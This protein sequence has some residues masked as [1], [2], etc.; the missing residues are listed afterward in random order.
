[1]V[2]RSHYVIVGGSI[3]GVS[4]A[5]AMRTAGFDGRISI[6]EASAYLP[7]ERPPLSKSLAHLRDP[8]PILPVERYDEL[9]IELLLGTPVT[10]LDITSKTLLLADGARLRA[11]LLLLATGVSARRLNVPGERLANIFRLRDLDDARQISARL[12]V[13]GPLVIVG[14][15][16]I[17]LEAA[18]MASSLGV[19]VTIVEALPGLL[20]SALGP[21]L[22]A[23]MAQIHHDQGVRILTG[24]TVTRFEEK[25]AS[26]EVVLSDGQCL[27][28][29]TVIVGCG[30]VPNDQLALG[31]GV[32]CDAGIVVDDRG[33]TSVDWI[34]AAGDV[35]SRQ[36]PFTPGR[37][38]IE[39]WEVA[40]RHGAAVGAAMTG[41][42]SAPAELPYFWSEQYG[43]Q[44]QMY[45]R[46]AAADVLVRR[47]AATPEGFVAFWLRG[48]RMTAAA[49]LDGARD[50]RAAKALIEHGVTVTSAQLS[51]PAV[52]LRALARGTTA[53]VA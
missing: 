45:G 22:G 39:H 43:H 32:R 30:V 13:G 34:W 48:E 25:H 7:Y 21:E 27:M 3:A 18:A 33:R 46:P 16:F 12:V 41:V 38:R 11:D 40:R 10:G 23:V 8:S 15:G 26:A 17:G 31:A 44:L 47:G 1:M 50:V 52:S 42:A 4:A 19:S 53:E 35:T 29:A 5:V 51:D 9:D 28:A 14:G 49:A 37:Q 24:R 20:L 6:V 2:Q 36:T